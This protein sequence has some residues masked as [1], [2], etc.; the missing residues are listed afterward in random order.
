MKI[1]MLQS[2]NNRVEKALSLRKHLFN[3]VLFLFL[4]AIIASCGHDKDNE[5][6]GDKPNVILILSDDQGWGDFSIHGNTN[7]S[8]PNI[9]KIGKNGV[10][11][12][13]F[14]VCAVCSPTRAELLTG[15]YHFRGGVR[16][17][18]QGGERLDLDETTI[19][20]VFKNAGYQTAAYGKWHNGMQYP[21]HPNG[22]GFDD[23]Y[24]F[25]SGHWGNYFSPMLEHNGK[26]V[27]GE[28][29]IIDDFT[30]HGLRFIE[31]NKDKPFFLYLPFNTPHTP[32]QVPDKWWKRVK[33]RGITKRS[34]N[35]N[36]NIRETRA[37]LALCENIDW[38]VGRIQSKLKELGLT[39]NTI[40]VYFNDN[41]PNRWRW[42]G[43][44][45]GKK[46]TVDEGGVRSPLFM[47]WKS[48]IE[49]GKM[50]RQ[51]ASATDLLPTL[52]DICGIDHASE[53]KLDGISLKPFIF[54]N[55]QQD[56]KERNLASYWN[57]KL[58]IRN[59]RFRL[60]MKNRLYD[61]ENDREQSK[62]VSDKFPAI[63]KDLLGFKKRMQQQ[64]DAELPKKDSRPFILGHPDAK[65]TQM[66]ARDAIA[67]GNIE[68]SDRFPNCTYFTNWTGEN[69]QLT[70][71]VNVPQDGKFKVM[72][73][74]T[75]P[76]REVG[77][78]VELSVGESRLSA[79]IEEPFES[80]FLN[81]EK[82]RVK[83]RESYAKKFKPMNMGEISL[84]KGK[85]TLTLKATEI[86]NHSVMDFRLLLFEKL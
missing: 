25:C 77:S 64:I 52:A 35:K 3:I 63:Q 50:V 4:N 62:D 68:R 18:S 11:F 58:S 78:T 61:I 29:F 26:I 22:R 6:N 55:R 67:Y 34:D 80:D 69:D 16:S 19:A 13:N 72:L 51:L 54:G 1:T 48:R 71:D 57:G 84:T 21:Y 82:D 60:D 39:E 37:A 40:V 75:C 47:Q 79:T 66:P 28:G 59:Q 9:D 7:L 65:Y 10:Q 73:Y 14:Y 85:A 32:F 2:T 43:G 20:E 36:E 23:Y 46:G 17:T 49:Q 53:K 30:D 45:R 8:T 41:G 12:E 24:G 76:K 81:V 86:A 56:L 38:N 27:Q 15:R 33:D 44:M 31:N 5:K 42:N 70:W 74:Y 83:R